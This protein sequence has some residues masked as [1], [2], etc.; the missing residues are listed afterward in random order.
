MT[1]PFN[2][3]Y[4]LRGVETKVSNY[5]NYRWLPHITI[6]ACHAIMRYLGVDAGSSLLDYGA[7]L[8]FYVK[9]YRELGV[10]AQGYDISEFAVGQ[11]DGRVS[12]VRPDGE[13]DWMVCKDVLEH[14][15][16]V[17]LA[18]H[19]RYFLRHTLRAVL[20]CVPVALEENGAYVLEADNQDTTHLIRW[21]LEGW[22]QFAQHIID[23]EG[24]QFL[25]SASHRLP[26]LKEFGHGTGRHN[27]C[28]F[29]TLRR[30][31]L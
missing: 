9:A 7:A 1:N 25:V 2:E 28:A 10:R 12:H 29:L 30:F 22:L 20:I 14:I 4:F 3:D 17:D 8:G 6:P 18:E 31:K 27:G 19:F 26:G 24:A 5:E 16:Y 13:F 15:N 23:E 11:S 21:T